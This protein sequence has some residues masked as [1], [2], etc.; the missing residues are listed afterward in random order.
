MVH[1]WACVHFCSCAPVCNLHPELRVCRAL[2]PRHWDKIFEALGGSICM[3]ETFNLQVLLDKNVIDHKE[4]IVNTSTEATQEGAL[5]ELLAKV[6]GKWT[7][8]EFQVIPYKDSKDVFIL[9]A[10]DEI[11]V[12]Q[13]ATGAALLT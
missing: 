3:D 2:K 13:R 10:I 8:I 4:L 9:G 12:R 1:K 6:T 5:E 11:Q 7:D